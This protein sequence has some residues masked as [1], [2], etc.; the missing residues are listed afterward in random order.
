MALRGPVDALDLTLAYPS[1]SRPRQQRN[2]EP[3]LNY[4]GQNDS[5]QSDQT[6]GW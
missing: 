2:S 5:W 6:L 1:P 3:K 4:E